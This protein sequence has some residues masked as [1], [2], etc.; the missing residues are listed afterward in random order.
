MID[1]IKRVLVEQ[2][3]KPPFN[4][5]IFLSFYKTSRLLLRDILQLHYYYTLPQKKL[6]PF[7]EVT[8]FLPATFWLNFCVTLL[9][10]SVESKR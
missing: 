2:M 3:I 5:L 9:K 6:F 8:I 10:I 4:S 1:L 7:Q